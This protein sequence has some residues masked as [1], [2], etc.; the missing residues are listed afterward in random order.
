MKGRVHSVQSLG[1]V[2]GPG[3]RYVVFLQEKVRQGIQQKSEQSYPSMV[4][5]VLVISIQKTMRQY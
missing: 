4:Q 1:A 5:A 3:V 2:D